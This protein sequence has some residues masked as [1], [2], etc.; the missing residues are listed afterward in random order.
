MVPIIR[1]AEPAIAAYLAPGTGE[2]EVCVDVLF[3]KLL[4]DVET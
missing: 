1:N 4:G 3:A 2:N